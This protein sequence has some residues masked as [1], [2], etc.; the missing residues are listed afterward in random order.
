MKGCE[1]GRGGWG[2]RQS[3]GN[4]GL[5]SLQFNTIRSNPPECQNWLCQF[6]P[7]LLKPH[8]KSLG[9]PEK[10]VAWTE[11]E[12]PL[13]SSPSLPPPPRS[14]LCLPSTSR[15]QCHRLCARLT[16]KVPFALRWSFFARSLGGRL[17]SQGT[18]TP[19]PQPRP[20]SV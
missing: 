17:P 14:R 7:S 16:K 13:P 15:T 3:L 11:D 12:H 9:A 18:D 6:L 5:I 10:P 2:R 4:P 1:G 8:L 19:S 20:G